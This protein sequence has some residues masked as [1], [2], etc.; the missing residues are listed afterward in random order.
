[1]SATK[2]SNTITHFSSCSIHTLQRFF[3]DG[4]YYC[5]KNK[6]EYIL[7]NLSSCGNGILDSG[8]ECDCG[9]PTHCI[10]YCC[11]PV[12]CRFRNN[13]ECASGSCCDLT[14]SNM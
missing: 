8:E 4:K 2:I 9:L 11:D 3:A 6:P 1:M 10:N 12:T 7:G 5:L 13:T 14:V